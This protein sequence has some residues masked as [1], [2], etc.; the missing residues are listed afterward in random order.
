[1]KLRDLSDTHQLSEGV[2]VSPGRPSGKLGIQTQNYRFSDLR[3]TAAYV[4]RKIY[5]NLHFL[6]HVCVCM[7]VLQGLLQSMS[8]GGI[9]WSVSMTQSSWCLLPFWTRWCSAEHSSKMY[10]NI[11]NTNKRMNVSK[12]RGKIN[13]TFWKIPPLENKHAEISQWVIS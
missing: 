10:N 5:A 3:Q 8:Q 9:Q 11:F 4:Q 2:H 7:C 1:M 12:K 13:G 6:E